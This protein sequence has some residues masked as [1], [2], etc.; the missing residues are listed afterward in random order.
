MGGAGGTGDLM[1]TVLRLQPRF[2]ETP[3]SQ[4]TE[5]RFSV[6]EAQR[7]ATAA[8]RPRPQGRRIARLARLAAIEARKNVKR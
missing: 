1:E 3:D 2:N 7:E 8:L 5:R 4:G 6:I